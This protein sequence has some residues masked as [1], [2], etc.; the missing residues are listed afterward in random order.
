MKID[1]R[2]HTFNHLPL[3]PREGVSVS[4]YFRS[5]PVHFSLLLLS[6]SFSFFFSYWKWLQRGCLKHFGYQKSASSKEITLT[7]LI[8]LLTASLSYQ[9]CNI[10][11]NKWPRV[12]SYH[13]FSQ[14]EVLDWRCIRNVTLLCLREIQKIWPLMPEG[15][16]NVLFVIRAVI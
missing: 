2:L 10:S 1:S 7:V 8:I 14:K 11:S 4:G 16:G 15:H 9:W 6:L 5:T 13:L 12:T 3:A